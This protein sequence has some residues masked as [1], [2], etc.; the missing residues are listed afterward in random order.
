VVDIAVH[1]AVVEQ[2]VEV[3]DLRLL[4][5]F[6]GQP[7]VA[8]GCSSRSL[9]TTDGRITLDT[10]WKVPMSFGYDSELVR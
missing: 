1:A 7:D 6:F 4:R 5:L 9:R 8:A 10:L 3:T 2:Q